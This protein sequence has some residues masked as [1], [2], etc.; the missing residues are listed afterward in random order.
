MTRLSVNEMTTFR[1]SFDEDVRNYREAGIEAIGVWRQKLADYGED[2]GIELLAAS[3]LRASNVLWAGGF[4]G[5]DYRSYDESLTD[6]REAIQLAR[7]L[8]A[9]HVI[10]YS[11][12]RNGHTLN[13]A[14]R[15]FTSALEELL[16]EAEKL[17]VTLALEPMH[18]GCADA[19]TFLTT[20]DFAISLI[21]HL[22]SPNLKLA[23]DTYHLGHDPQVVERIATIVR[24]IGIVH[25][26]D[27]ATPPAR[28][29]NRRC[30]GEG[31][32]PL[33][34]IVRAL[35]NAGYQGYYDVELIGEDIEQRD[36]HELLADTKTAYSRLVCA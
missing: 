2:K 10:V 9:G 32:L 13:H 29:Q 3:G 5:S 36:Y 21:E 20:L 19:W 6:A 27:G 18:R 4:T 17:E 35:K 15:L 12:A 23:F 25:L 11:G 24:H 16:P 7:A 31:S 33:A 22:G 34:C 8:G 1:W 26:A 14:K 30:L 28:E